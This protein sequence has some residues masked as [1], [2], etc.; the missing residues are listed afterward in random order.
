MDAGKVLL[1]QIFSKRLLEIPFYQRAYVW[2]EE[3]WERLLS[4]MEFITDTQ[5]PYFMGSV[6]LKQGE[7]PKVWENFSDKLYCQRF[8]RPWIFRSVLVS[9]KAV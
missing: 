5:R 7:A 3:Q 8:D 9:R 2:K 6:I 1:N 4:D